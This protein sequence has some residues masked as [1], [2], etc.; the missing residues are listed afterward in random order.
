MN[1]KN[2]ILEASPIRLRPIL[3]TSLATIAAALPPALAVGPGAESRIP[4]AIAIIGGVA[5]ST[6]L[7]LYVVPCAYSFGFR[8]LPK[9][10]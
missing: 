7:T 2:A 3:M 6:F 8:R 9:S 5:V 4:L 1:R 10:S